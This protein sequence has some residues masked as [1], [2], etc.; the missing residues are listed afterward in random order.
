MVHFVDLST[1]CLFDY[2]EKN[3]IAIKNST[4]KMSETAPEK[5]CQVLEHESESH[6]QIDA[7]LPAKSDTPEGG[8]K[9]WLAVLACWCIMFNTF[10]YIN[11]FGYVLS[12]YD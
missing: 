7:P 2:T 12:M 4:H 11:A 8:S 1:Y 10:G 3:T 9:G 5:S 6:K